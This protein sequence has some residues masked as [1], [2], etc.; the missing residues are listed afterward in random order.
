MKGI[1]ILFR[2]NLLLSLLVAARDG[3]E[4]DENEWSGISAEVVKAGH[5]LRLILISP[6]HSLMEDLWR[7]TK[8]T[9]CG[10]DGKMCQSPWVI[11]PAGLESSPWT[12]TKMIGKNSCVNSTIQFNPEDFMQVDISG[13]I[14][15]G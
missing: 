7:I 13:H 12:K 14:G 10:A 8:S 9:K 4:E 5:L 3:T 1:Y 11:F 2:G 15:L 6:D